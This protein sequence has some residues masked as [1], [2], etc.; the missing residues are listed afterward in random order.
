MRILIACILNL[1]LSLVAYSEEDTKKE[2]ISGIYSWA[3]YQFTKP[4]TTGSIITGM[5]VQVASA[6][7]HMV[8]VSLRLEEVDWE[9]HQLDIQNGGRDIAFGATYTNKRAEFANFSLPYRFEEN[10][11]FVRKD[12][13]KILKFQ[14]TKGFLSEVERQ[15]YRLGITNGFAYADQS[16]NEFI[17]DGVNSHMIVVS[18]DDLINLNMLLKGEIDGFIADRVVGAALIMNQN[19]GDIIE[20]QKLNIKTPV[21]MMFSKKTV[22]IALVDKFNDAIKQFVMSS[23]YRALVQ[24][25]LYPILLLETVNAEWF[26]IIGIIGTI[27]FAISGIAIAAKERSTLFGTFIFAMLPSVGGGIIRDIM[28]NKGEEVDIFLHPLYMYCTI[29]VVLVGFVIVRIFNVYKQKDKSD[30]VIYRFWDN[31]LIVSDSLGQ[32]A[33][34]VTGVVVVVVHRIAPLW[35]WVPF[36]AFITANGGG[37]IRDMLRRDRVIHCISGEMSA[38]VSLVWGFLF[39]LFLEHSAHNPTPDK[40]QTAVVTVV[41]GAFLTQL[42][43]HYFKIPNIYFRPSLKLTVKKP[44]N[45]NNI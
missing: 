13:S 37:I 38:E 16:I 15:H 7:S 29:I 26:F 6:L 34:I 12:A 19:A 5:D 24:E 40:I 20:E 18:S 41:I 1:L 31:V 9:K 21:H 22:P 2:L 44:Q 27:S 14:D 43:I 42:I 36:F 4:T 3:P 10:S 17:S 30:E 23:E 45:F 8:G 33:F 28:I 32:A 11:L 39:G 35:L 25:Y